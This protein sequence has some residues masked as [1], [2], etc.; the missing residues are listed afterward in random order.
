MDLL[1]MINDK[2]NGFV[3]GPIMLLLL[4]GTGVYLSF[5]VGFIQVGKFGY[6][7]KNTIGTLFDGKHK[8]KLVDGITPFQAVSTALASTVGTGNITGIATA[9]TIGGPGAVFWMWVS[10][11]FGMVTKYSE[12]LLSL[13]FREKNAKGE[14]VGGPMYYIENGLGWKWLAVLFAI[15][16]TL[17][18]F[19]IGNM[20][21]ANSIAQALESTFHIPTLASGIVFAIIVA[22]VII[23][24]IKSI[25]KVN[26]KI[27]PFMAAFY[28]VCAVIVLI[29]NFKAIPAAFGLIFSNAFTLHSAA[30]GAAGYTIMMAMRYGFARGVFSNEAGLGSAPIA[31]AASS[32]KDPVEQG[33]W[34][35]FEV[36][37]DT[38]VICTLTALVVLTSGLW[39]TVLA[40]GTLLDG[41][42]LSI[43]AFNQTLPGI[44]GYGVTIGMVLFATS[45][46]FGW[47]YY[48][49][50]SLEYLF[51]N[52]N[53]GTIKV[54][55]VIYRVV[56]VCAVVVGAT[57]GLQFIWSIADT[58]NGLMAIP[59]LIALLGLSGVVIKTTKKGFERRKNN[60][61][62]PEGECNWPDCY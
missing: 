13:T 33:L 50:K 6:M 54:V 38:I 57:G 4:V 46:M 56:F 27:V 26:E 19:G 23:G 22:V 29:L 58:L 47:S 43:A 1:M 15:F 36:F 35:I 39:H 7:W 61:N 14:N 60:E 28:I 3:W 45:T 59:N 42:P 24:G 48:G 53:E 18:S 25:A 30:G 20:T 31:H 52:T 10:A 11:F 51:K 40:D 16:A 44:G 32:T 5:R 62:Y 37:L 49:E 17:A 21:Q 2:V 41:A 34:G 9:I 8:D 55:T 12:I